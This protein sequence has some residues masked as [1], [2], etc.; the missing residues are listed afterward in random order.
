MKESQIQA[1]ILDYLSYQMG[2]Y[3]WRSNN[4]PVFDAT[5]KIYRKMPKHTPKG[6]PDIT[7]IKEGHYIAVE[8]KAPG[9]YLSK[10]QKIFKEN[11]EKH[12]GTYILARSVE[13]VE[14][15]LTARQ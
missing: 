2:F 5:K 13:D 12:G 8:V 10:D 7:I 6:L 11:V 9:K 1:Q 3:F 15:F 4:I 14:K